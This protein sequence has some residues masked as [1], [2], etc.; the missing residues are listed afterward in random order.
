MENTWLK[1]LKVGDKVIISF[2]IMY[3]EEKIGY[4]GRLTK[5]QII[6]NNSKIKYK[7]DSGSSIGT[8]NWEHS[9]LL[10]PTKERIE[11]IEKKKITMA[12]QKVKWE[13]F[14]LD[15]LKEIFSKVKKEEF[16]ENIT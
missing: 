1:N 2:G 7:K 14:E 4:I 6:L 5:T 10:E 12:L 9:Q 8:K 3:T 16:I 11:K 15:L 13:K